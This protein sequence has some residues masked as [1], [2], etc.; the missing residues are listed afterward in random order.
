M[1]IVVVTLATRRSFLTKGATVYHI[2]QYT[3]VRVC[4]D[5]LRQKTK[6]NNPPQRTTSIIKLV[7]YADALHTLRM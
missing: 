1:E 7:R 3:R 5:N 2:F 6:I 4:G